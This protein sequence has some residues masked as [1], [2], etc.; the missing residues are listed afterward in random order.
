[1]RVETKNNML[2]IEGKVKNFSYT[3]E[4]ILE[5]SNYCV[6]LLMDDEIPDNN[7][8]A[9]GYNGE[10]LW[11]ISEIIRFPYPEAYISISKESDSIFSA[12]TYNGVRFFVDTIQRKVVEKK[13]T[14]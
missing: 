13:I 1:M 14:K 9:I 11:N 8:V 5:F 4:E 2:L 3:I 12:V 7:I 6:L 10:E